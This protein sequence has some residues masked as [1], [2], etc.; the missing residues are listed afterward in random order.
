MQHPDITLIFLHALNAARNYLE[1]SGA[2]PVFAYVLLAAEPEQ[3]RRVIVTEKAEQTPREVVEQLRARLKHQAV[4]EGYRAV[5][6]VAPER[7]E[8]SGNGASTEVIQV[9]IDHAEAPPVI[10]QVPFRRVDDRCEFGTRDG[11]GIMKAGERFIFPERSS[12]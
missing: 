9:A 11:G 5:A 1:Q 10:W 2:I 7:L 8:G 4:A 6:I 3:L 12:A